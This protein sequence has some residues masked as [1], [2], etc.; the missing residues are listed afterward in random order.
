[1]SA[2]LLASV[3]AAAGPLRS[4]EFH[5]EIATISSD[6]KFGDPSAATPVASSIYVI[7]PHLKGPTALRI[8]RF[9]AAVATELSVHITPGPRAI[10]KVLTITAAWVPS[11]WG[12]I[13]TLTEIASIPGCIRRSI[14]GPF[15]LAASLDI[16]VPDYV[17]CVLKSRI[18]SVHPKFY[19]AIESADITAGATVSTGHYVDVRFVC[20][21]D[22][23]GGI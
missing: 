16:P 13:N 9:D 10:S 8:A 3:I 20:R 11:D 7:T 14:G 6:K 1:M 12:T 2:Q 19:M 5:G 17:P 23:Y 18:T 22:V 21:Y 4:S 15:G